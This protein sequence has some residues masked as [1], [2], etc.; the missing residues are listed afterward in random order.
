MGGGRNGESLL[1]IRNTKKRGEM[2]CLRLDFP[3]TRAETRT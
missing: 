2:E 3:R 1:K